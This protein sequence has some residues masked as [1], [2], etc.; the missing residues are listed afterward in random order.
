MHGL[1]CQENVS[2]FSMLLIPHIGTSLA[3]SHWKLRMVLMVAGVPIQPS[4]PKQAIFRNRFRLYCLLQRILQF[5]LVRSLTRRCIYIYI[6][7]YIYNLASVSLY[8]HGLFQLYH[9][10]QCLLVPTNTD[11]SLGGFE[12]HSDCIFCSARICFLLVICYL[13]LFYICHIE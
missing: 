13:F 3:V 8:S 11:N 1:S 2:R 10:Y 9:G 4:R 12:L 7:I 5:Q 6:Y